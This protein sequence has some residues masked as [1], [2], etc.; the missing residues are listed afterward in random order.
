MARADGT[1]EVNVPIRVAYDQWTQF[2]S[3]PK[4]MEGVE[5]VR[6]LDAKRL[7]WKASVGGK[8]EEWD[9]EIVEQEPDRVIAWRSIGG[10]A[11]SGR[12][13][14]EPLGPGTARVLVTMDYEPSGP[15]G[16]LGDAFGMDDRRVQGDLERFKQFVESRGDTTGGWRGEVHRGAV[17][18]AVV[19]G[20]EKVDT[21][22]AVPADTTFYTAGDA[23][24]TREVTPPAGYR[25]V[26]RDR[27]PRDR[28]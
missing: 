18:G 2:E 28:R 24:T 1:I 6:Q 17:E 8:S 12:V 13:A 26:E 25:V 10:I 4:F 11:N 9:A 20:S 27:D 3:F 7:H 14:F 23:P 19:E 16:G 22:T 5:E 15:I 21:G